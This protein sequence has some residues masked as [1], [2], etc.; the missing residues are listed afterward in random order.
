MSEAPVDVHV[1]DTNV[2]SAQCS[3]PDFEK[4]VKSAASVSEFDGDQF[5]LLQPECRTAQDV[6]RVLHDHL[7]ARLA[8]ICRGMVKRP[9]LVKFSVTSVDFLS[10]A[11][12]VHL[13]PVILSS[14]MHRDREYR[15]QIDGHT[16]HVH[17]D[18]PWTVR[19]SR[20]LR[21][22]FSVRTRRLVLR[23]S[24][25]VFWFIAIVLGVSYLA[26]GFWLLTGRMS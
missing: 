11:S 14:Y 23:I 7:S 25:A 6:D 20:K 16:R 9:N 17:V 4:A 21:R 24:E 13:Y 5:L 18:V 19:L 15:V 8:N 3:L 10:K 1:S 22:P 12:W 26:V 2:F